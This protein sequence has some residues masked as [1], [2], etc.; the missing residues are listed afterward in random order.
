M[1]KPGY[2]RRLDERR[3]KASLKRQI[4]FG[5]L[6]GWLLTLAGAFN[7]YFV[8]G[9]VDALWGAL[10]LA[11]LL[12]LLLTIVIPQCL[13]PIER[14]WA[15]VTGWA[16]HA[17]FAIL[18]VAVYFLVIVPVG[19]VLTWRRGRHP[20]YEWGEAG[21]GSELQAERWVKKVVPV[22]VSAASGSTRSRSLFVQP[23]VVI[24]YFARNGQYLF[25]PALLLLLIL[26]LALFFVQSSALAPLIY[27]LF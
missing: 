15:L 4:V 22:E 24:G 21:G 7:Y 3:A 19:V 6:L 9:A 20:F 25:L 13:S 8:L 5:L 18:L 23:F 27:T 17:V 14:A 11:G 10:M 12:V 1:T 16:G 2:L 26:G